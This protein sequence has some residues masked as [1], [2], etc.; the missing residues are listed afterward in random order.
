[1]PI[2][3]PRTKKQ[4][5]VWVFYTEKLRWQ[6]HWSQ[7]SLSEL[8]VCLGMIVRGTESAVPQVMHIQCGIR[9]PLAIHTPP[10]PET[11]SPCTNHG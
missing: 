4:S 7:S 5:Q 10:Q 9:A 8:H 11:N 1:M 2:K 3:E 6:N